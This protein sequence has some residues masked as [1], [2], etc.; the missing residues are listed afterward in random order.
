MCVCACV[1]PGWQSSSVWYGVTRLF[2][3][4][5]PPC[6]YRD[7]LKTT[8]K[9]LEEMLQSWRSMHKVE[10]VAQQQQEW[11]GHCRA[12]LEMHQ[13][14]RWPPGR[15]VRAQEHLQQEREMAASFMLAPDWHVTEITQR[16]RLGA[17]LPLLKVWGPE[18]KESA[19]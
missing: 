4:W 18:R 11:P 19:S 9:G 16:M 2:D 8:V 17:G 3:E 7:A 1:I 14:L 6:E 12:P 5:G 13:R 10:T 15:S